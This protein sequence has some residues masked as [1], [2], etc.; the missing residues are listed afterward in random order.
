MSNRWYEC[1]PV[2]RDY[3]TAREAE[4]SFRNGQDWH[5]TSPVGPTRCSV[6]DFEPGD[7][8]ELRFKKP[9][10]EGLTVVEV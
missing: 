6:R 1:T 3:N 2:D 10:L 9:G 4:E 8:I 5:L 7:M